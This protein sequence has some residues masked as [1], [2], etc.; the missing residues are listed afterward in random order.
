MSTT[1]IVKAIQAYDLPV[2]STQFLDDLDHALTV[3]QILNTK[4]RNF[5]DKVG[6]AEFL[7][8]SWLNLMDIKCN[9]LETFRKYVVTYYVGAHA[10]PDQ[11]YSLELKVF[12]DRFNQINSLTEKLFEKLGPAIEEHQDAVYVPW[13][14]LR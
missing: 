5:I 12:A 6:D 1:D 14:F 2:S 11:D 3:S 7:L 9:Y 13:G 4:Y 8:S 10:R